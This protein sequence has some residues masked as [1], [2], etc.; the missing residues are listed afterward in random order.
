LSTFV[1]HEYFYTSKLLHIYN[2][3]VLHGQKESSKKSQERSEESSKIS[4]ETSKEEC[5]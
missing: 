3:G 5:L 2:R 4:K 1:K